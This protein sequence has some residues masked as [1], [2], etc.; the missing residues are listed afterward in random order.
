MGVAMEQMQQAC[1]GMTN[2]GVVE[3][4]VCKAEQALSNLGV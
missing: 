2:F 3:G 1:A 4:K